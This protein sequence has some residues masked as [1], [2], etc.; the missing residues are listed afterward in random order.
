MKRESSDD[1]P[2]SNCSKQTEKQV[3]NH[4]DARTTFRISDGLSSAVLTEVVQGRSCEE[5]CSPRETER[6]RHE[7][8]RR[9]ADDGARG[10]AASRG[11]YETKFRHLIP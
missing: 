11:D 1:C 6:R 3:Q 10:S 9:V 4:D 7:C 5:C 8:R 2:C